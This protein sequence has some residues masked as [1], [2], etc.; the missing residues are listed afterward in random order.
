MRATA[1]PIT[2]TERLQLIRRV[3]DDERIPLQ[4]RVVALLI[5]LYAQPLIKI[6]RLTVAD[7]ELDTGE[8]R[9][10][11]GVGEA[12]P[13][14]SPFSD[15]LLDHI[16]T[17]SNQTTATNPA[18]TLLFPGRRADQPIHPGSLRLRLHRL[19]IPNLNGRTRAIKVP[20]CVRC[21]LGTGVMG[22]PDQA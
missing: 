16:A 9:L 17:R 6:A 1:T 15:V 14:I 22:W 12:V 11:L 21:E 3:H 10:R 20:F 2:Q 19:G 18:S 4:D 8:V 5:L 13:I 7:V